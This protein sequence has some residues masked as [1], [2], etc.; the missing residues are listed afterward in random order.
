[1]STA[2]VESLGPILVRRHGRLIVALSA[3]GLVFGVGAGLMEPRSYVSHAVF[4]PQNKDENGAALAIASLTLGFR[5]PPAAG[6]WGTAAYEQLI[7][8]RTLLD[9]IANDTLVLIEEQGRRAAVADLLKVS[10]TPK[11]DRTERAVQELRKWIVAVEDA[12]LNAVQLTVTTQ[13]PS[14]SF[15]IAD[16]LVRA[17]NASD[18]G[19][20]RGRTAQ[21]LRFIRTQ[22]EQSR[23]AL[24]ETEDALQR[25]ESRNAGIS[26]SPALTFAH[27]R[28][29][30][31][32]SVRQAAVNSLQQQADN[33]VSR[34]MQNVSVVTLVEAPKL[35][36]APEPRR[37]G[38]QGTLGAFAAAMIALLFAYIE[39][40]RTVTGS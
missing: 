24:R 10:P 5:P 26:T 15:A 1:M 34:D 28:L 39:N 12:R 18:V 6:V 3:C 25:F 20:R 32:L 19:A 7:A 38:L 27:D 17:V 30:R 14:V 29:L 2:P 35:P 31:E 22:I 8:S 13:W 16:R 11:A 37:L 36:L 4:L 33:M 23:V 21:D 9:R 40:R